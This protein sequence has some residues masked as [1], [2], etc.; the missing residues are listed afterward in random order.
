LRE[1]LRTVEVEL[2]GTPRPSCPTPG[3]ITTITPG[4]ARRMGCSPWGRA[5]GVQMFGDR[6]DL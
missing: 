1:R 3:G 4:F 5:T 6:I 2:N